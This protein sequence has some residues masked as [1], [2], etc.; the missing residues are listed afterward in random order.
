MVR[1]NVP[2]RRRTVLKTVGGGLGLLAITTPASAG[3]DELSQELNAAR[4]QTLK[5]RDVQQARDDGYETVSPY[6][7]E[8][9]FH[10]MQDPPYGTAITEP[11]ILVYFT[12]GSY[13]PAPGA[14]HRPDHDDDLILGAVEYAVDSAEEEDAY[15]NL[16]SDEDSNR[17]LNVTEE[18]GWH[19]TPPLD[20]HAL[21][22]WVHRN[23]PDGVF[24]PF[25][26]TID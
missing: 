18:D 11:P 10:F 8:M 16:F 23:N 5:Y 22:A 24:Q 9:G 7:P 4:T 21:H 3:G 14:P 26:R 6:V 17:H 19:W 15:P 20:G 25:N 12:N 13:N 1:E 2:Y